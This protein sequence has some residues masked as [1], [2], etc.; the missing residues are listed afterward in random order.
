MEDRDLHKLSEDELFALKGGKALY[1]II[2][3]FDPYYINFEYLYEQINNGDNRL[4]FDRN[5]N[6]LGALHATG[7]TLV[8]CKEGDNWCIYYHPIIIRRIDTIKNLVSQREELKNNVSFVEVKEIII[9]LDYDNVEADEQSPWYL[10]IS[11]ADGTIIDF[12]VNLKLEDDINNYRKVKLENISR[13]II[14]DD[15]TTYTEDIKIL[16]IFEPVETF[17]LQ[18]VLNRNIEDDVS[19]VLSL[20]SI[21]SVHT[22]WEDDFRPQGEIDDLDTYI[23]EMRTKY[24]KICPRGLPT[25]QEGGKKSKKSTKTKKGNKNKKQK[26]GKSIKKKSKKQN[27]KKTKKNKRK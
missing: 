27:V 2:T 5:I 6:S 12:I 15:N 7:L 21:P 19:T 3:R 14:N 18:S 16:G 10:S 4:A 23:A 25:I 8:I 24:D 1:N 20:A 17:D 13:E 26:G 22:N 11:K 9:G